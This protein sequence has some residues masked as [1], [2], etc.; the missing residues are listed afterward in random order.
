MPPSE[1]LSSVRHHD[2]GQIVRPDDEGVCDFHLRDDDTFVFRSDA[3]GR[4]IEELYRT[5]ARQDHELKLRQVSGTIDH[6]M[7]LSLETT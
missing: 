3:R 6:F 7:L 4:A 2:W 1:N 5:Q